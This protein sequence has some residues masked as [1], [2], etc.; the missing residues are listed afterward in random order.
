MAIGMASLILKTNVL[1]KNGYCYVDKTNGTSLSTIF[2]IVCLNWL[3]PDGSINI[4]EYMATYSGNENS[5]ALNYNTNGQ[6]S[7]QLPQGPSNDAYKIYLYV[8]IIDNTKGTTVFTIPN[9]I[10]VYPNIDL[11]SGLLDDPNNPFL[12]QLNSGNL[13][14]VAKNVIALTTVFNI[15]STDSASSQNLTEIAQANNQMSVLREFMVNKMN[16]LSVSDMSSIKVI[17]SALSAATQTP[18]QVSTKTAVFD[19]LNKKWLK[20]N[21]NFINFHLNKYKF[22]KKGNVHW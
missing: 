4:Y 7:L 21:F 14:L 3:D 10:L 19:Y 9:P 13:N 15:Q 2:T 17:S 11:A 16:E 5:I 18:D 22:K 12:T 6:I 20:S 1:P 8:N